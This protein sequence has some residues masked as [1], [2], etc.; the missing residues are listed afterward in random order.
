MDKLRNEANKLIQKIATPMM[1][2]LKDSKFLIEGVL[3]P[4]EFILAGDQLSHKCPTW[5][6]VSRI[7][8]N[9]VK[10]GVRQT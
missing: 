1:G 10:L 7:D 9:I 3:T 6:Y 2:V 4:E 5:R 8:I